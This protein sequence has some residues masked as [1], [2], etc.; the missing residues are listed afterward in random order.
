MYANKNVKVKK[1]ITIIEK[2][3]QFI[4][5]HLRATVF[6]YLLYLYFTTVFEKKQQIVLLYCKR[7]RC[8]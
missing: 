6:Y 5:K 7:Y 8:T 4:E 1:D 2:I 3:N